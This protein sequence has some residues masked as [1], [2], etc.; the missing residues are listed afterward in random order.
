MLATLGI[1]FF[2]ARQIRVTI[3]RRFAAVCATLLL[4]G[5]CVWPVFFLGEFHSY[6]AA[7]GYFTVL[8]MQ[9]YVV[10]GIWFDNYLLWIG[11]AVTALV[12]ATFLIVP[13]FFWALTL[14]CGV[15]LLGS[16][17]YVRYFWR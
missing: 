13:A 11:L 15:M 9:L 12:V 7:F 16:G 8:W 2:Q 10:A 14:L 17:F 6:K 3:D 1:G 4:F 5:Y